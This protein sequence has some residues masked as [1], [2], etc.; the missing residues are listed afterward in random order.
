MDQIWSVTTEKSQLVEADEDGPHTNT[1]RRHGIPGALDGYQITPVETTFNGNTLCHALRNEMEKTHRGLQDPDKRLTFKK[2]WTSTC[3]TDADLATESGADKVVKSMLTSM[4]ERFDHYFDRQGYK[5]LKNALAGFDIGIG[6]ETEIRGAGSL[7]TPQPYEAR[8]SSDHPLEVRSVIPGSPADQEGLQVGDRIVAVNGVAT[9]GQKRRDALA[10][11][12]GSD[13][14][15]VHISIARPQNNGKFEQKEFDA[16]E[17][18]IS[19]DAAEYSSLGD[20]IG[21][22]KLRNFIADDAGS[23]MFWALGKSSKDKALVIDLR[24][25]GG[26]KLSNLEQIAELIM[27]KGTLYREDVRSGDALKSE[28][29]K[30]ENGEVVFT[31]RSSDD[32]EHPLIIH[33][34]RQAERIVPEDKPIVVLVDEYSASAS[35]ILAGTLQANKRAIIVGVP[36]TGKSEGQQ[37]TEL[38][39]ERGAAITDFEFY[40][41]NQPVP[42]TGLKPDITAARGDDARVDDQLAQAKKA[43]LDL[44][45]N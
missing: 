38:P 28:T 11:I 19:E 40:P 2:F 20:G 45:K 43:A 35:E 4:H 31:S 34:P 15:S 17:K 37:L 6:I 41:G 23:K 24:N 27:D 32:P 33:S 14:A 16:R 39:F 25:N 10:Q 13:G 3:D 5:S 12:A 1:I 21:Y 44:V 26:G 22:I 7:R 29:H 18:V 36:T 42:H 8:I 9:D 30:L